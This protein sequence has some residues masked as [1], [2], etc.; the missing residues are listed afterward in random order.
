M[1]TASA[2]ALHYLDRSDPEAFDRYLANCVF[3][4]PAQSAERP[5]LG[6]NCMRA[7]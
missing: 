5:R 3:P 6:P 2:V 7:G 4:G 1:I